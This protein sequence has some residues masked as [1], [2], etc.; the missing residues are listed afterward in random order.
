MR[1]V[2]MRVLSNELEADYPGVVIGG[3]GDESHQLSPSD[4]NED[5]TPG[6][7]PA[8]SDP[9]STPE[10]RAIDVML[11][12]AMSASQLWGIIA[13]IL[14][15]PRL[16][17]RLKYINFLSWQW[18]A[19]TGWER[20]DNSDD[21]HPGH[22][23]FSGDASNDEDASPWLT[24]TGDNDMGMTFN[25]GQKLDAIV[26]M[27]PT[28]RL[29]TSVAADGTGELMEFPTPLV[30]ELNKLIAAVNRLT[31]G[32]VDINALATA[33]ARAV[34]ELQAEANRAAAEVL[35]GPI[36]Q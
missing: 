26:N 21:P 4:H 36:P 18:S 10:H 35:D 8:Q 7:K 20:R 9:D 30:V 24:E 31:T 6:S 34:G 25:Q 29:D 28:M 17:R 32:G 13:R 23:H 19:S 14:A 22:A 11:G 5:D 27:W 1:A 2:N 16:L 33:T 15:T 3:V 12:P